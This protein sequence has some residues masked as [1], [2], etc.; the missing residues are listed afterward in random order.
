MPEHR[1]ISPL[2]AAYARSIFELA[3]ER[4]TADETGAELQELA[5]IIDASPDVQR[6]LSTPAIGEDERGRVIEKVFRG[7][8]SELLSNTLMVMNRKG[9]LGLLRQVVDAY[10]EL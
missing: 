3:D 8:V 9:R 7:R 6:F 4:G 10:A 5:K 2:A 1:H